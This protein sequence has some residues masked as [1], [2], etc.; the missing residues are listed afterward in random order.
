MPEIITKYPE[1]VIKVLNGAHIHCG[2]GDKQAILRGC[3]QDKFCA[4]P[5][6]ELCIY[7]LNDITQMN[8]IHSLELCRNMDVLMPLVGLLLVSFALG[9]LA[10]I[11]ISQNPK[12]IPKS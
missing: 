3:P 10:G 1:K 7:G 8:Q 5:T 2:I 4:T 6:G 9:M 11:K 12:S